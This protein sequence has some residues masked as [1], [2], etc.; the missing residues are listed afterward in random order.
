MTILGVDVGKWDLHCALIG[1]DDKPK[2]QSF[3]NSQL[4]FER[5]HKW[6]IN[7]KV[8]RV[9]ACMEATGGWSEE[10]A[11]FLHERGHV[12]SIVNAF[13]IKKFGESM[14]SR[15][16][17]DKAD[18]QL[19]ARYCAAIHPLAWKPPTAAERRLQQL[20]RR[21]AALIEMLVQERNRLAAPG[22]EAS[23]AS[24]ERTIAFL[25]EQIKEIEEQIR[26]TIETDPTLRER[27]ALLE[28]IPGIAERTATTLLGEIPHLDEF[29]SSRALSAFVGVCPREERSG[30]SV[31]RSWLSKLGNPAVRQ[32]LYFPAI[33][34]IRFNPVLAPWARQLRARGKRPKQVIAAAMRRL[35][36]LAY[37]VLRSR[38]PFDP[39]M[40]T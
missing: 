3:P 31:S 40:S 29:E 5:L 33:I 9:H 24:I 15:T 2:A 8:E 17:T 36:V 18:A 25:E 23:H 37:G 13:A 35:L 20:V 12:V 10:L 21:R 11:F 34:A 1:E 27:K 30:R 39:V 7:R 14:L 38:K 4:G 32:A 22:G 28:S 6:L 16:K 26:S 19:I